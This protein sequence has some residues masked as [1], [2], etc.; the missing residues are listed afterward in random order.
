MKLAL[1][2]AGCKRLGAVIAARLAEAGWTLALHS[3]TPSEL[4]QG[5]LAAIALHETTWFAFQA[6]LADGDAVAE[7]LARV[8]SHF[9][10]MPDLIVNN[11]SRFDW[12]DPQSLTPKAMADHLAVNLTAPVLLAT[13]LATALP[14]GARA[15]VVNILDQRIAQPNADQLSYTLSKQ[16]L[17]AATQTL[18]RALAPNVRVNGVAPGLV[19]P[20]EE[21][22]PSQMA[23][24]EE[25]MPLKLL[26]EPEDVADAVLWLADAGATTGQILFVDGGAA[27]RSFERDF[28]FLGNQP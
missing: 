7:L 1:V 8:T 22:R 2:T 15:S 11:A 14:N 3:R 13:S 4:D 23:A 5:L 6:D 10:K 25:M 26:P 21:F 18:A 24:L 12:D 19:I 20:T 17:A 9:G 27:Q 28:V 16:A